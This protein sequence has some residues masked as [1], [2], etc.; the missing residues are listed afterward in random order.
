[1]RFY[2][3][4]VNQKASEATKFTFWEW[5][6]LPKSKIEWITGDFNDMTDIKTDILIFNPPYVPWTDE[7]MKV[8]LTTRDNSAAWCGGLRGREVIDQIIPKV[9]DFLTPNG[10]FYF[11][12]IEVIFSNF[13]F[14]IG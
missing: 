12:L 2:T 14:Y 10:A 8:A 1:M 4:D 9:R 11:L 7:E 13:N 3:V 5:N 6:D